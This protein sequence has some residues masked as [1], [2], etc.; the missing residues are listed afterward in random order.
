MIGRMIMIL[1]PH[2]GSMT[3]DV[4]GILTWIG[5]LGWQILWGTDKAQVSGWDD[6]EQPWR[7]RHQTGFVEA[8]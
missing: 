7:D 6:S 4:K 2:R 5:I 1:G 3:T 8:Q